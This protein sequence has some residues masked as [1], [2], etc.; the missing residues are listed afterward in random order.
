M[1]DLLYG[2]FWDEFCDWYVELKKLRIQ[3]GEH[4]RAHLAN[5]L[6]VF[7][8]ALRLLH[9]VMPFLSEELWQRLVQKGAGVPESLCVAAYPQAN[10]AAANPAAVRRMELFKELV[11]GDARAAG[12]SEAGSETAVGGRAV[13][14]MTS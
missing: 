1:A 11:S 7:E 10:M 3:N 13:S 8:C 6:R 9:P 5:L 4:A 2:F 12:R 14:R